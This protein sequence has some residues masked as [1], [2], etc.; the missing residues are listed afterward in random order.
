MT[1]TA[2]EMRE[3]LLDAAR[4]RQRPRGAAGVS[5]AVDVIRDSG[6]AGV[7]LGRA[8]YNDPM[9]RKALARAAARGSRDDL[10]GENV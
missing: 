2:A 1:E 7:R 3:R 10:G 4:E 8:I 6:A 5:A 9:L